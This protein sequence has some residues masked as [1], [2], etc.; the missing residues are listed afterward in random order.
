M[1]PNVRLLLWGLVLGVLAA[2][3]PR[4][5]LPS[6]LPASVSSRLPFLPSH[7]LHTTEVGKRWAGPFARYQAGIEP[8]PGHEHSVEADWEAEIEMQL[9]FG[10][11]E[12]GRELEKEYKRQ[13][14]EVERRAEHAGVE[15]GLR[16]TLPVYFVEQGDDVDIGALE[17]I[18]AEINSLNPQSV[19]LLAP[20]ETTTSHLVVTSAPHVTSAS[21]PP[22]SFPSSPRLA[23]A[24]LRSFAHLAPSGVPATSSAVLP[25][26]STSTRVL[27]ALA[28][29]PD[30]ELVNVALPVVEARD[31]QWGAERWWDVGKAVYGLLHE[32]DEVKGGQ[33]RGGYRNAVVLALGTAAPKKKTPSSSF[34]KQLASALA[35]QT[36]HAREQS[37]HALYSSAS[38]TKPQR[39]V[40]GAR[41]A[42]YAA[43]AAAGDGEGEPLEGGAGWRLGHLPVR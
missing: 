8:H 37:L 43:V 11:K 13:L 26:S 32:K 4:L 1:A 19:I 5:D 29:D 18:G 34:A 41:V 12:S 23:S 21:S 36:S 40:D 25:L 24:L 35:D 28:L 31:A 39:G 10:S 2:F 27:R 22:L 16:E 38:G 33:R 17:R 14:R 9:R 3:L 30:T 6:I 15:N 42:L 20:H 7:A